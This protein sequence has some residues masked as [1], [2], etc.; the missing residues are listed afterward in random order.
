MAHTPEV[1]QAARNAYVYKRL[2]IELIAAQLKVSPP[3]LRKWRAAA[4]AS[5]DDWDTARTAA[6]LSGES[7][8]DMS[9]HVIEEFLQIHGAVMRDLKAA[10]DVAPLDK[11][12][13]LASLSDAY[14]KTM[15]A[16]RRSTPALNR[17]AVALEVM[18]MMTKYVRQH[19]PAQA[20]ELEAV[21]QPFSKKLAQHYNRTSGTA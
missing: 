18:K 3:T 7:S 17:Y 19:A 6:S 2:T 13:A 1:Q 11:V 8:M 12:K 16:F 20:Q 10:K 4:K 14:T 5:G 15:S 9:R 21:L